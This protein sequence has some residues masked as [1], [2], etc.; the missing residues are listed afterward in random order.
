MVFD[1]MKLGQYIAFRCLV[2]VFYLA[3]DND[4]NI[5]FQVVILQLQVKGL[6]H[7]SVNESLTSLDGSYF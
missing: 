6:S 2:W 4:H 1:F 7:C 3:D 5:K